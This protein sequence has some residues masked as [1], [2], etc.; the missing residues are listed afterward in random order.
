MQRFYALSFDFSLVHPLCLHRAR[1]SRLNQLAE[2]LRTLRYSQ[3][4][5]PALAQCQTSEWFHMIATQDIVKALDVLKL[6]E[7]FCNDGKKADWERVRSAIMIIPSSSGDLKKADEVV[8]ALNG[9]GAQIPGRDYVTASF[10]VD[11]EAKRIL[12]DVMGVKAWNSGA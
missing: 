11:P 7:A 9:E 1:R 3:P 4:P 6:S 10:L 12:I 5:L 2:Q 8:L